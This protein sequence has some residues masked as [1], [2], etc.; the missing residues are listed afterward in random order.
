MM[1]ICAQ[2]GNEIGKRKSCPF[3]GFSE[4]YS[5]SQRAAK[6]IQV[7]LKADMPSCEEAQ[8]MMSAQIVAAR[9]AGHKILKIIHGYGSSGRGGELRWCLRERLQQNKNSNYIGDFLAGEEL[10]NSSQK[11]NKFLKRFPELRRDK[12]FNKNNRG[13]TFIIL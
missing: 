8:K 13:V 3:C 2:C 1:N 9:Q 5:R 7:N 11:G 12:D 4:V 6:M 10:T